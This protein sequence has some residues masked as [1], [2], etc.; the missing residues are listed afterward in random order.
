MVERSEMQKPPAYQFTRRANKTLR[1][2][3]MLALL[4]KQGVIVMSP[5]K[6]TFTDRV[7]RD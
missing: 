4:S 6:P 5:K 3:A 2:R 7:D 1:Q